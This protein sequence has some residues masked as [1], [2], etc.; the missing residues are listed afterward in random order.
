[1]KTS[2]DHTKRTPGGTL[3]VAIGLLVAIPAPAAGQTPTATTAIVVGTVTDTSRAVIPGASV[4]LTDLARN[5]T[6]ETVTDSI[7]H[8][9][10]ASVLPGRYKVAVSVQGFRQT[11]VPEITTEVAKSSTVNVVL[12]VGEISE[13]VEVVAEAAVALQKV[14]STV[15]GTLTGETVLRLPNPTR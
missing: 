7:G 12:Q 3:M 11:V 1:M 9:A 5:I 6:Q 2:A 14:D 4:V 15:G 13:V 8:Y 10:F